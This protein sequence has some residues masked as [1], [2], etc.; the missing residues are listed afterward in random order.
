MVAIYA[1]LVSLTICIHKC[2]PSRQFKHILIASNF[3][4]LNY[5]GA[6]VDCQW[7]AWNAASNCSA[8]CGEGTRT[9]K[10]TKSVEESGGGTCS[11][12]NE[13]TVSCYEGECTIP[14]NPSLSFSIRF[15]ISKFIP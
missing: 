12:E 11:G 5:Q 1:A 10:R 4:I 2:I 6:A 14:G 3:T 7:N 8:T 9:K 13:K 15:S